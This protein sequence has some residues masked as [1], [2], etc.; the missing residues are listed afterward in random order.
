MY[1]SDYTI[2]SIKLSDEKLNREYG[3]Y[4]NGQIKNIS[5]VDNYDYDQVNSL[6]KADNHS[7]AYDNN[8]NRIQDSS[9][10][11]PT[12]YTIAADSN[13]LLSSTQKQATTNSEYDNA[14]NMIKD[15]LATYSYDGL[16]RLSCFIH[17]SNVI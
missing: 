5:G 7:Y 6:T 17:G 12:S 2:K 16:N 14:G 15:K 4:P 1:N 3:Y 9:H 11:T 8:Q 10:G 13:R